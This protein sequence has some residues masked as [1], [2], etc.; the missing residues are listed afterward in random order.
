MREHMRSGN[1]YHRLAMLIAAAAV[2]G[3]TGAR[4]A[5]KANTP[6][7]IWEQETLTGDWG[8]A[9]TAL[10]NK[11]IELTL[12]YI[13]EVFAV[14][15]GGLQRQASYEGRLEFSLDADLQK[16]IG[17]SGSTAHVTVFQIHDSGH[18]VIG[19]VGSI[20]DSSNIDALPTTRLYTAW[21]QQNAFDNRVSL[22]LGKLA[23]DEEFIGSPTAGGLLSGAFGWA[24]VLAA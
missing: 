23:A 11:G 8:G 18:N 22:R 20:A 21:F 10:K 13:G 12:N 7:S 9:R 2:I 17:W 16:L 4:A 5:E 15:S 19:N 3:A 1:R 24:T 14:M 6:P